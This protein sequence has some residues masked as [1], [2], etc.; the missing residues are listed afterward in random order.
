MIVNDR[1]YNDRQEVDFQ[2]LPKVG[3]MSFVVDFQKV[4]NE[5]VK[6][7]SSRFNFYGIGLSFGA[8]TLLKYLGVYANESPFSACVSVSNPWNLKKTI[9]LLPTY[10]ERYM[11]HQRKTVLRRRQ[12]NFARA[13]EG[14]H[15]YDI[16]NAHA[17]PHQTNPCECSTVPAPA[18]EPASEGAPP[19]LSLES[20]LSY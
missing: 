7:Y 11:L 13:P 3:H 19:P 16:R 12:K 9:A 2:L 10:M 1:V 4:I 14:I 15:P 5:I 6:E 8:N 18:T 17:V 20:N